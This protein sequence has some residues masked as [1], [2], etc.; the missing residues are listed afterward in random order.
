MFISRRRVGL[1]LKFRKGVQD[2]TSACDLFTWF[3]YHGC[4][5]FYPNV[6]IFLLGYFGY[7]GRQGRHQV[8]M[9]RNW[10][11]RLRRPVIIV[12]SLETKRI[13]R[14]DTSCSAALSSRRFTKKLSLLRW[15]ARDIVN[16]GVSTA[17]YNTYLREEV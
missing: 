3:G 1:E 16:A 6:Q 8:E 14:R 7:P 9:L 13:I 4:A 15:P 5:R 10:N 12:T 2:T 11:W 17:L